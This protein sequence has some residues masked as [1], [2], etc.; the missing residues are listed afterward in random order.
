MTERGELRTEEGVSLPPPDRGVRLDWADMPGR[1]RSEIE[2]RLGGPVVRAVTQPTGFTPGLAARLTADDGHR[3]FVKAAGTQPNADTPKAHRREISIVAALPSAAPVPR[4]LWSYDEGEIGWVVLA[5]EDVDGRHPTQPWRIDEL[6][7]VVSA[8]EE[9]STLLTP[10]P[11]PAAMIGT[12]GDE[13]VRGWRRLHEERPSR[14][15]YVDEWSRRHIETLVAIEDTVG[16]ALEGDTLLNNDIRADNILLTPERTWFVDWPHAS[17]GPP[18][19]DVVGFAPSVTMQGGPPPEEVIS[20]HSACRTAESDAISAAV[21][22]LAGYFTHKAVQPPPP[23][24]P[25]VRAFQDAQ[26][27]VARQWVARRTVLS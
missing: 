19:L 27:V 25:T 13:F 26:G 8:M 23:G 14:L 12:A 21:V 15:E 4:L 20:R 10:S 24:L 5:F 22:A 6:D 16:R 2:R 3:V 18:W 1:V 11:L 7:R 9:L 17:V